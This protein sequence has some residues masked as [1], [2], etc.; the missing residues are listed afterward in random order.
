M[1]SDQTYYRLMRLTAALVFPELHFF[2]NNDFTSGLNGRKS[3][4][5]TRILCCSWRWVLICLCFCIKHQNMI[6][7]MVQ[8]WS[9]RSIIYT[10]VNNKWEK[11]IYNLVLFR[12]KLH[13]HIHIYEYENREIIPE[14][15]LTCMLTS[16]WT[17]TSL[18]W[19]TASWGQ[20]MISGSINFYWH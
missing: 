4:I 10:K 14:E 13:I 9:Y 17:E 15:A 19:V 20:H 2:L 7:W 5:C 18:W 16:S 11:I 1:N 6:T 12:G 8:A 3:R